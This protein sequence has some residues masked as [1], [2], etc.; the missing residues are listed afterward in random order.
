MCYDLYEGDV[1]AEL[2]FG[3]AYAFHAINR[4]QAG[5]DRP[6]TAG[7]YITRG[8]KVAVK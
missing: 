4:R 7:L 2:T 3:G 8:R 5:D 6:T 1:P